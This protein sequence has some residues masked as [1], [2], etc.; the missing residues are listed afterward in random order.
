MSFQFRPERGYHARFGAERRYARALRRRRARRRLALV[1]VLVLIALVVST[2]WA[3][4]GGSGLWSEDA[5]SEQSDTAADSE[6]TEDDGIVTVETDSGITVTGLEEFLASDELAGVEREIEGIEEA[7]YE[8]GIALVDLETGMS[9]TYNEGATFYSAST[10]KAAYCA[11]IYE[12]YGDAGALSSTVESCLEWSDNESYS[13]LADAFG[14]EA[15]V[16]WLSDAGA[17]LTSEEAETARYPY[18]T[19]AELAAVWEEIYLYG[20]SGFEG[21][22]EL[23]GYLSQTQYGALA[24]LLRDSYEVWSKAGWYPDDEYDIPTTNEAGVVFSDCGP[25]VVVVMT[26]LG[27]DFM[28][29]YTIVDALNAAHGALCGGDTT[30]MLS[31]EGAA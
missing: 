4:S 23:S 22:D 2:T 29:L 9:I 21:A 3:A 19:P 17:T 20:T 27:S 31:E 25:Y 13:A 1:I 24:E 10:I 15:F 12:T 28:P 30:L 6:A 18:T 11:M 7:G 5:A 14:T 16:E 26:T 8:V